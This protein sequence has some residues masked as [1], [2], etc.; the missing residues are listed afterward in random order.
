MDRKR[1]NGPGR[2]G[3]GSRRGITSVL[4]ML[5][6]VLF[7][8]MALGFYAQTTMS[9]QISASQRRVVEAHLAA[10]SGVAFIKY[11][12]SALDVPHLPRAQLEE[13][14]YMQLAARLDG[15]SNL[16]PGGLGVVGYDGN[17]IEIPEGKDNFVRMTPGGHG[18]RTI[19]KVKNDRTLQVKFVGRYGG[20]KSGVGRGIEIS[21]RPE[22]RPAPLLSYGVAGRGQVNVAG[23]GTIRGVPDASYGSLLITTTTNHALTMSGPSEVSGKVYLTNP[24]ATTSIGAG[25]T[26][27]GTT[28]PI[29]RAA[30]IIKVPGPP[31]EFPVIDTD[32]FKPYLSSTY[33]IASGNK[34]KNCRVPAGSNPILGAGA[35][36]DGVL[37]VET[38]N[39]VS[40]S[41]DCVIRGI[42]V[43]QTPYLGSPATNIL[44]FAGQVTSHDASTLDASYGDIRN[45]TGSS[46]IC[47]GFHVQFSG[48]YAAMS[49]TIASSQLTFSGKAGGNI[50][51]HV[52]GIGNSVLTV[53]GNS[54][55]FLQ[56]PA[57]IQWPAGVYFRSKYVPTKST[58]LEV[59]AE[60]PADPLLLPP[61][62]DPLKL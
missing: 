58:Y 15:T 2:R 45:F 32:V 20:T 3:N 54:E 1:M 60:E 37:Y 27:G 10:E 36:I 41:G 38:P 22:Q 7:S 53:T 31:P 62:L 13:E 21:F 28:D 40:F 25:C 52:L 30:N 16:G 4:A 51:G 17:Q 5:Y 8:A 57:K 61:I 24:L 19:I 46:I 26:V 48:G 55:V 23:N 6:L 49:G 56:K 14:I 47:P 42:I 59:S 18:F 11:H 9:S 43:S 50:T 39:V 44:K 29:L 35:T 33:T 34:L 12:L